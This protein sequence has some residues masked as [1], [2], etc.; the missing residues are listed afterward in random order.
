VGRVSQMRPMQQRVW[1]FANIEDLTL[2]SRFEVL[3]YPLILKI[4]SETESKLASL[5]KL[6]CPKG[7]M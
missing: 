6:P 1:T 2:G 7:G 5:W 3:R 4:L